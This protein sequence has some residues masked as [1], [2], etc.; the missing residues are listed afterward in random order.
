MKEAQSEVSLIKEA[1]NFF[2]GAGSAMACDVAGP[3]RILEG[4]GGNIFSG[5]LKEGIELT[6]LAE[7]EESLDTLDVDAGIP[8]SILRGDGSNIRSVSVEEDFES[9]DLTED[10]D[11]DTL[12]PV[13][14]R[15]P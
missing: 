3:E 1:L 13:G 10:A 11:V 5:T 4:Y 7:D 8:A 6:E 12:D 2:G 15:A 14:M 9:S